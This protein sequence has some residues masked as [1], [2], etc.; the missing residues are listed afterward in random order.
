M[1]P[2]PLRAAAA[3]VFT[4]RYQDAVTRLATLKYPAGP[5]AGHAALLRAAAQYS[6][7]LLG[8]ERDE[9]LLAQARQAVAETR[10][11]TPNLRPDPSTFSPRFVQFFS[12]E[13]RR[14]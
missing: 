5:A 13:T 9:R 1:P 14:Q 6:L 4:A 3:L 8:G 12:T 2:A 7:Y 10:R 11:H